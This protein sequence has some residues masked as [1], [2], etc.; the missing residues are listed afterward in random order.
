[1]FYLPDCSLR[2]YVLLSF[3][4]AREVF[5]VLTIVKIFREGR[6]TEVSAENAASTFRVC[7]NEDKIKRN[8]PSVRY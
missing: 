5:P 1:M 7:H 8:Q 6:R 3:V 4:W 2:M